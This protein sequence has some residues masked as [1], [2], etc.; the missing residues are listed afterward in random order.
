MRIGPAIT[1]PR[2]LLRKVEWHL[3]CM[4]PTTEGVET[5]RY[6]LTSC[7]GAALAPL[8]ALPPDRLICI[9]L[10]VAARRLPVMRVKHESVIR[11]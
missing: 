7:R 4:I 9:V 11:C 8:A 2:R 1:S 10:K 5:R 3:D 6:L